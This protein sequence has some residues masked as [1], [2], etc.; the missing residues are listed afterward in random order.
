M[1]NGWRV[2]HDACGAT[3]APRA[4]EALVQAVQTNC[5]IADARHAGDLSLCIY[6]LQMREF[7]RWERGLAFGAAL[8]R[9]AVG[10]WIA[11]REA[12]WA[13]LEA[14]P[15]VSVSVDDRHF[16]A[17]DAQAVNA[18]LAPLGL[19]YGAGLAGAGRPA[20][21]LAQLERLERRDDGLVLQTCGREHA[22]GLFAPPAALLGGNTIVLRREALARLLWERFEAFSLH[23]PE[24][25]F[26][27]LAQAWG[28]HDTPAFV[29]AL[30]QLV[31]EQCETLLL[32]ELGEYRAGQWLEPG[33]AAIRLTLGLALE[34]R[35][36]ELQL[37][38]VRDHLADLEVTLPTLLERR[39]AT[40][41]HFWFANYEGVRERLFPSLTQAY[42]AWRTGDAGRALGRAARAGAAHFRAL[43]GQVLALHEQHGGNA[44]AAIARLLTA[45]EAVCVLDA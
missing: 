3:G 25:P 2:M 38:A 13:E 14:R 29:A 28:L 31:D 30:P 24:S 37:R 11:Q 1:S 15:F 44:A 12:L 19:V 10:P 9:D 23:R 33:W 39:A 26:K 41:L 22:R 5:D 21:F 35:R 16:D 17:M 42:T 36:T 43:G 6:L 4:S 34:G 32:H 27:A 7:Y 8:G 40:A 18:E 45:P 20:F